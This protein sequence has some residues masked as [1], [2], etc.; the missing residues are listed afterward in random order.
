[1]IISGSPQNAIPRRKAGAPRKNGLFAGHEYL[2][3]NKDT[4]ARTRVKP[5]KISGGPSG[6]TQLQRQSELLSNDR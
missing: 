4:P 3:T 1:M 2:D 6:K 5:N